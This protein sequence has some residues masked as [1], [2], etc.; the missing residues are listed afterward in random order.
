MKPLTPIETLLPELRAYARS[1]SAS[2]DAAEELVQDAVERALRAEARPA[3]L[4]DLRPWMFRV[5]RNLFY[6]ELRRAR[7]R[8]EYFT[9]ERRL[10]S[11][12]GPMPDQARDVLLRL[13]F[14]RMP[15]DKREVL[16]LVDVI[17]LKYAEA[18]EV[19][20]VAPGT[21]MSRLS[22]ARQ[23]LRAAVDGSEALETPRESRHGTKS[24]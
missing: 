19:V 8:K 15:E 6:D 22:R 24:R 9:R 4:A 18:A 3:A 20:G 2:A 5:I 14:E 7:V 12:S 16:F 13:A 10:F 17:G 11:E 23:A 1:L 21:I